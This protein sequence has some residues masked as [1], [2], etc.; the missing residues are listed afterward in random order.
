M[1][2]RPIL[3]VLLMV[4]VAAFYAKQHYENESSIMR[5][6]KSLKSSKD[7]DVLEQMTKSNSHQKKPVKAVMEQHFCGQ[8]SIEDDDEFS[9]PSKSA[10]R[11]G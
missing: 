7:P 4:A 9:S 10:R 2:G 1:S 8:P 6:M 3:V 11:R 5:S